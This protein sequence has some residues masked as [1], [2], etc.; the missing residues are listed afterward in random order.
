[1][2]D[3]M[4]L[5]RLNALNI[6]NINRLRHTADKKEKSKA[7]WAFLG[8]AVVGLMLAGHEGCHGV[9]CELCVSFASFA[10]KSSSH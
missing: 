9:L 1:M 4:L 2:K 5:L 8:F 3:L 7:E 6:F 10:V